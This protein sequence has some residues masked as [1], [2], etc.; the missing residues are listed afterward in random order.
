MRD[1]IEKVKQWG[2]DRNI[3][4]TGAEGQDKRVMMEAQ[5]RYT[6]KETAELLDAYADQDIDK[7]NDAIGDILVTLIVGASSDDDIFVSLQDF[8]TNDDCCFD[9]FWEDTKNAFD[10][11]YAKLLKDEFFLMSKLPC[12]LSYNSCI[13]CLDEILAVANHQFNQ[14]KSLKDCLE[15]AYNEIKNRTG[16]VVNS[17]FIKDKQ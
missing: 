2:L 16:K 3:V 1:L 14:Q 17:Q 7:I 13:Y 12:D 4:F 6:L 9:E 8:I 10:E 15:L 11:S 5:A